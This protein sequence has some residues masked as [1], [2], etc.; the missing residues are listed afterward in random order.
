MKEPSFLKDGLAFPGLV[1][2]YLKFIPGF[3]KTAG[4]LYKLMNKSNKFVCTECKKAVTEL[5]KK[6]LKAP[7]LRYPN[8]RD[9][10]TLTTNASL[11][12]IGTIFTQKQG[13]EDRATA[14]A[15]KFLS[16]N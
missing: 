12:G 3:R 6:L 15:I 11:T 9:P 14:Y 13:T 2:C 8:M 1:G 10:Y 7:V 4:L 5:K 16:K